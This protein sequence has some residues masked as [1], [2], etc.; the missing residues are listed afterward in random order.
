MGAI[1][2]NSIPVA[3]IRGGR[4]FW[5]ING[6]VDPARWLVIINPVSPPME[7]RNMKERANRRGNLS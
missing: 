4:S 6:G 2:V 7:K 1:Q 3:A 5:V